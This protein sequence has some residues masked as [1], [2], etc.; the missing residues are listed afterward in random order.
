MA[1]ATT[2]LTLNQVF[3]KFLDS[4]T[5]ATQIRDTIVAPAIKRVEPIYTLHYAVLTPIAPPKS[6]IVQVTPTGKALEQEVEAHEAPRAA[7]STDTLRMPPPAHQTPSNDVPPS[8]S[9]PPSSF[10]NAS[11]L[12]VLINSSSPWATMD[13]AY[14]FL[15]TNDHPMHL[16][17][18]LEGSLRDVNST[19]RRIVLCTPAVST[20]AKDT[21]HKLGIETRDVPQPRHRNFKTLFDHW[22]DT[23]AKL[24]IFDLEDL[25]QFVYLD[26]DTMVNHNIDELFSRNTSSMVYA[27]R[28]V[29]DC[30]N[31]NPHMNAGLLVSRPNATLR[32]E[33]MAQLEDP[34]F[35]KVNKGDQEM[36]DV[37]LINKY[38]FKGPLWSERSKRLTLKV[39]V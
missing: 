19:R 34:S 35:H 1:I 12:A 23:L 39:C 2:I 5:E 13:E 18:A 28:D 32:Q 24:A 10:S 17:W 20:G 37:Y 31:G 38:V 9:D 11:Q 6:N 16:I 3:P 25:T 21:L 22:A 29:I 33:L 30:S 27:M 8:V 4:T 14:V 15:L 26:A 7:P 36:L